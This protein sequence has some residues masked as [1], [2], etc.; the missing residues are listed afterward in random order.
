MELRT[1]P[2]A[3]KGPPDTISIWWLHQAGFVIRIGEKVFA[4][5]LF[6]SPAAERVVPPP[7][8]PEEVTGLDYVL[9]THDHLDHIDRAVWPALAKASP[10]AKMLVPRYHLEKLQ[11]QLPAVAGRLVGVGNGTPFEEDGFRV[12][13]IPAAH[14]L[15]EQDPVTGE[16]AAVGYAVS[17]QGVTVY[18]AGD[19][20][21]Y[22]GLE[23]RLRQL[24]RLDVMLLPING[25]SA[26]RLRR[27]ILGNMTYQEAADLA[28]AVKPGLVIPMHYD[29]YAGNLENP[30]LFQDYL[31]VK[32][33]D[34]PCAVPRA[35]ERLDVEIQHRNR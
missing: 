10:E 32:Y 25:R 4:I 12:Q 3:R 18:H 9:G 26:S 28:G 17:Y 19:C 7:V 8:R 29:A 6:L 15:H 16:Y 21:I 2:A 31:H 30:L 33:P 11:R 13:A 20:C 14:E 22:E 27:G 23:T 5:D 34:V 35:G 24:G 1:D